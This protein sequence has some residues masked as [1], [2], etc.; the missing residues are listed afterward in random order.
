VPAE[1]GR[2]RCRF[3]QRRGQVDKIV[4][5]VDQKAVPDAA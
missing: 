2:H 1:D 5:R 4:S 3:E